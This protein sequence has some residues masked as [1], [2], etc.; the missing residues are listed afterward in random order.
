M[1]S[2]KEPLPAKREGLS[3]LVGTKWVGSGELWL[4]RLQN[5]ARR[6]ECTLAVGSR[7]RALHVVG[8]RQ[9]A[10]GDDHAP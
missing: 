2:K 3:K 1:E 9:T 10:G 5:E 6:Y 8:R 4:D 7:L